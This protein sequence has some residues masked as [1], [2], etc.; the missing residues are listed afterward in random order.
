MVYISENSSNSVSFKLHD[1][2][3][4]AIETA[5]IG[6]CQDDGPVYWREGDTIV[7]NPEKTPNHSCCVYNSVNEALVA[8][9]YINRAWCMICL[10][11]IFHGLAIRLRSIAEAIDEYD[12]ALYDTMFTNP[13]TYAKYVKDYA[14]YVKDYVEYAKARA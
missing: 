8:P 5:L 14:E 9:P 4:E 13:T 11:P 7:Q 1:T 6:V 3:D 12:R 10:G 2:L